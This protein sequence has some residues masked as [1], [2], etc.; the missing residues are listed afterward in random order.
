MGRYDESSRTAVTS[1]EAAFHL[2]P[3]TYISNYFK[4]WFVIDMQ[5]TTPYEELRPVKPGRAHRFSRVQ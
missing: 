5:L 2:P 1:V 4:I 3:S